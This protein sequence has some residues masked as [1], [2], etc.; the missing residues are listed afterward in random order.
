M[1]FNWNY[2]ESTNIELQV[3]FDCNS[4]AEEIE[5]FPKNSVQNLSEVIE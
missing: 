3:L 1:S 4:L 5:V 2:I